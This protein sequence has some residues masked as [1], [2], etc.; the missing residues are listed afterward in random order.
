MFECGT[1]HFVYRLL[2][3]KH[4]DENS[5][6]TTLSLVE[7]LDK[8]DAMYRDEQDSERIL[9]GPSLRKTRTYGVRT[10]GE[11]HVSQRK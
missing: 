10:S 9:H 3:Y 5:R 7:Q 1:K 8:D 2:V 11:G 6:M 4:K